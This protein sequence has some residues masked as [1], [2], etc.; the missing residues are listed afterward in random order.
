[1]S[2]SHAIY[3]FTMGYQ[4]DESKPFLFGKSSEEKF[5]KW[6]NHVCKKNETD[7]ETMGLDIADL[8]THSFRK[9]D[10]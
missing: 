9:G 3:V 7:F 1:M 10:T 5:S 8:G 6:L 4:N 2:S